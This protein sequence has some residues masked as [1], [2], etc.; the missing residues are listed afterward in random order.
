MLFLMRRRPPRSTLFP[1]TTLFRSCAE[2]RYVT[3]IRIGKFVVFA[4]LLYQLLEEMIIIRT[5]QA[6]VVLHANGVIERTEAVGIVDF[7]TSIEVHNVVFIV[8]IVITGGG[9][10]VPTVHLI[11]GF[12][13]ETTLF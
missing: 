5:E 10:E 2:E 4:I 13:L 11:F 8:H 9:T 12:T 1:Y 7:H 3:V 6:H